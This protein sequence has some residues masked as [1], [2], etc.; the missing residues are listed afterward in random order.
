MEGEILSE[1]E[2]DSSTN[3]NYYEKN[4]SKIIKLFNSAKINELIEIFDNCPED[5][6]EEQVYFNKLYFI[7]FI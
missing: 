5:N 1:N 4:I 7:S 2:N 3:L 6:E